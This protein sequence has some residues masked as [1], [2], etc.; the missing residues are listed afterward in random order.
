MI[1]VGLI[2]LVHRCRP[3]RGGGSVSPIPVQPQ[4]FPQVQ[5]QSSEGRVRRY[6]LTSN[7][8]RLE[9]VLDRI[10]RDGVAPRP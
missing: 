3:S 2:Q 4:S 6:V 10:G 5:P 8:Q 7:V 1:V 9:L